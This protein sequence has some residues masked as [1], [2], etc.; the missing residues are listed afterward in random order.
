[1]GR[2][3]RRGWGEGIIFGPID[4]L[5]AGGCLYVRTYVRT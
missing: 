4:V 1:M 2:R 3:V 5:A